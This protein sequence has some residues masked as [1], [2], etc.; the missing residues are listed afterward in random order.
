MWWRIVCFPSCVYVAHAHDSLDTFFHLTKAHTTLLTLPLAYL[1]KA[2]IFRYS[3][4]EGI[5]RYWD[6]IR[7]HGLLLKYFA[8]WGPVQCLTFSIVPEH[9]RVTFMACVSFFWLII[10]SSITSTLPK[11]GGAPATATTPPEEKDMVDECSKSPNGK[12][13]SH[14]MTQFPNDRRSMPGSSVARRRV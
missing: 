7:N 10:L 13:V 5:R 12:R 1:T 11:K 4:R 8:L 6:D 9:M 14:D 2:V 3:F